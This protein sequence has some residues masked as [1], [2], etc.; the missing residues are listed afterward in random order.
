ML[1]S[2]RVT[3][4][5]FFGFMHGE[6]QAA[7]SGIEARDEA[8]WATTEYGDVSWSI[9]ISAQSEVNFLHENQQGGTIISDVVG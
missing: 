7:L 3:T 8:C 1:H 5:A 6:R 2:N 9:R 4:S